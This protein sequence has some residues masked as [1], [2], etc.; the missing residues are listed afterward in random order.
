MTT[1]DDGPRWK[2]E[3]RHEPGTKGGAWFADVSR[4]ERKGARWVK[5]NTGQGKTL[6]VALNAAASGVKT[7][8]ISKVT[9]PADPTKTVPKF[10]ELLA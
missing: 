3:L 10:P 5:Q 4:Q 9:D 7:A 6:S 8:E 1:S 2:V